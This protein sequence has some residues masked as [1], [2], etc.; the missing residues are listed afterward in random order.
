M[1]DLRVPTTRQPVTITCAD[2]R[3]VEGH[4]FMPSHSSRH[5]GPMRADE[6][7]DTVPTFF[8]FRARDAACSTI[9]NVTT[10]VAF[11]VPM[12]GAE[13]QADVHDAALVAAPMA[14]VAVDAG[15][16]SFEGHV[17]I[18][19]PPGRQ[20]MADWMNGPAPFITVRAR[21]QHH[22]IHKRHITRVIEM[23]DTGD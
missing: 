18:D 12:D 13:A 10:V 11:T 1:T 4:I 6:W 22:L 23:P 9:F 15:G 21:G 8:P 2:G 14:R 19:L 16:T 17:I 3:A 20:R 5:M 7:S